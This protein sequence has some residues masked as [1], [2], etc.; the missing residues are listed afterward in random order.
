ML[1]A[2]SVS[3]TCS[4][5]R[6][7]AICS[8]TGRTS[9]STSSVSRSWSGRPAAHTRG[10]RC[11]R[12]ASAA[13]AALE[14]WDEPLAE[15]AYADW[16][17]PH[18]DRLERL[19]QDALEIGAAAL[20][21]T[22]KAREAVALA[23]EAVARQPLRETARLLLVRA[24]AAEGDQAAAVAAYLDL[25]RMLADELGIDPSADAMALYERLLRGTLPA[26]PMAPAAEPRVPAGRA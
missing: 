22:G 23:A 16:A 17:R 9:W 19:Y 13:R 4:R 15:D 14:L 2:R 7:A 25:R 3:Q 10:A 18:R 20:L 5:P 1:A 6:A 24:Y 12:G 8:G 11:R 21:A 26:H